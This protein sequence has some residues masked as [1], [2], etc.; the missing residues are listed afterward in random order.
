M[1]HV[2]SCF[3][4]DRLIYQFDY[5]FLIYLQTCKWKQWWFIWS[6][7]WLMIDVYDRWIRWF[8]RSVASPSLVCCRWFS[9]IYFWWNSRF[10]FSNQNFNRK[11]SKRFIKKRIL[12]KNI[13]HWTECCR[14]F[15]FL[16][17]R[18]SCLNKTEHRNLEKAVSQGNCPLS[19]P[20]QNGAK[21]GV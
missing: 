4:I 8:T 10:S 20:S 12:D 17:N 2:S 7:Y 11:I 18:F 9:I 1:I 6:I 19:R 15:I 16:S 5:Y 14:Y 21:I 13:F 3:L